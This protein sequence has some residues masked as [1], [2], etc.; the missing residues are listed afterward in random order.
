MRRRAEEACWRQAAGVRPTTS[1][2]SG[3]GSRR[4]SVGVSTALIHAPAHRAGGALRSRG[5]PAAVRAD[6]GD[7]TARARVPWRGVGPADRGGAHGRGAVQH[8]LR[9]WSGVRRVGRA[10]G[11]RRLRGD[12][13]RAAQPGA[14]ARATRAPGRPGRGG[15]H[16]WRRARRGRRAYRRRRPGLGGARAG[17][18]SGVHPAGSPGHRPPGRVGRRGPHHL[19]LRCAARRPRRRH[20]RTRRDDAPRRRAARRDWVPRSGR[21]RAGV[22][23]AV[24]ASL[25]WGWD[26]PRCLPALR[27]SLPPRLASRS[28]RPRP[29]PASGSGSGWSPGD[30]HSA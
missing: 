13:A 29:P 26:R 10:R 6:E 12:R 27:R 2:T 7:R 15:G 1:A 25:E 3:K 11:R 4:S 8:R 22:R 30:S 19:D 20:R 21:G 5:R 14:G 18:R 16:R 28:A 24:R 9:G 23:A 17:Q